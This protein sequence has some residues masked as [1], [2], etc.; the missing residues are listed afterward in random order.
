MQ[1]S[2]LSEVMPSLNISMAA[3]ERLQL[4]HTKWRTE[5]VDD[6]YVTRTNVDDKETITS[7]LIAAQ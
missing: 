7:Q 5:N 2:G 4:L 3:Y 1:E 6:Q